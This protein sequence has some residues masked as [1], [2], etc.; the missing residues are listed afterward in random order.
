MRR[1][2]TAKALHRSPSAASG[3]RRRPRSI[4]TACLGLSGGL[5]LVGCSP[6][7]APPNV[8][9]IAV[10]TSADQTIDAELIEEYRDRLQLLEQGFRQIHANTRFQFSLYPEQQIE[11]AIHRRNRAGLAP[12]LIF[13]NG[14]IAQRL[15]Q[16]GLVS[17]Y[18]GTADTLRLFN[19]EV[20]ARLRSRHGRLVGLPV[21]LQTQLACYNRQ[22]L[23]Q[24]PATLTDLLAA[25]ASGHPVGLPVELPNLLWSAG[26]LGTLPAIEQTL[27]DRPTSVSGRLQAIERWLIWLQAAS[28]QQ[29][30]TFYPN[31]QTLE[32]EF[33]ARRLD[34][35]PC[36]STALAR[37]RR[38]MGTALGV[39][40]LPAG[41]AGPA[42]PFN[43]L[44]ILALGTNSSAS[45]RK[46]ALE[47]IRFSVNPLTQRGLTLGSQTVLPANRFVQVPVSS[48]NTLQAMVTS[49]LQGRQ[50]NGLIALL[51]AL[52]PRMARAQILIT[53][54]VFG[55]IAPREASRELMSVLQPMEELNR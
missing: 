54:L 10:S 37:L 29:R 15:M 24:P 19:P 11:A 7:Q 50:V 27:A 20:L 43:H 14:D 6:G 12:D 34:W 3:P 33:L 8:L 39:S 47:F 4:L 9:Y 22:R 17:P 31:Q 13:T 44:R 2:R 5:A 42:R 52:K 30:V 48:S 46:R 1:L 32:T 51:Y 40:P 45:G 23:P 38:R 21:L 41:P 28:D 36:Q 53:Q 49:E 35:I 25:S 55:E 18:P 26:S 16:D